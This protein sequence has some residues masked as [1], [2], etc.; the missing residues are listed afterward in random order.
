M[1]DIKKRTTRRKARKAKPRSPRAATTGQ[2][3]PKAMVEEVAQPAAAE[4]DAVVK[5]TVPETTRAG[6]PSSTPAAAPSTAHFLEQLM[7]DNPFRAQ[8]HL[9]PGEEANE[10]E[11]VGHQPNSCEEVFCRPGR[12]PAGA[13][14]TANPR[15]RMADIRAN[16]RTRGIGRQPDD[17][18]CARLGGLHMI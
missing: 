12:A 17:D 6:T 7:R 8:S 4:P 13:R 16:I 15:G 5:A 14:N 1:A 10:L 3:Q 18:R 9:S 11:S 2:A